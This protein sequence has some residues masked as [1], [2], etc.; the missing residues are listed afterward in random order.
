MSMSIR[1]L[2][3]CVAAILLVSLM[4]AC[5]N[6]SS[7]ITLS[8]TATSQDKSFTVG[9]PKGWIVNLGDG[10]SP[11]I[12][13][14]NDQNTLKAAASAGQKVSFGAGQVMVQVGVLGQ[15]SSSSSDPLELIKSFIPPE[16]MRGD[17]KWAEPTKTKIG[18]L[19]V[20]SVTVN[21]AGFQGISYAFL[22]NGK[23]VN[24]LAF[25]APGELAKQQAFIDA[26][27]QSV[28]PVS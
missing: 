23:L 17:T 12:T 13:L 25:A 22:V 6:A 19:D 4:A 21:A 24:M 26:I 5:N 27:V 7:A 10:S 14:A 2:T 28:K 11:F 15:A 18:A 8:E 20:G 1:L 16:S 9:Y 3:R